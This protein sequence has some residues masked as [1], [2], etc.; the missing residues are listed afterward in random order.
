MFVSTLEVIHDFL[1]QK[2]LALVGVSRD[3]KAFS[4]TLFRDLRDRGYDM[5]PVNPEADEID[6][7]HCYKRVQDVDPAVEGAIVMTPAEKSEQ[8]VQ[9]CVAAGVERVWLHRGAGVG[10]VSEAAVRTCREFELQVV[11]GECPFMFLPHSQW[12]HRAHG[13]FRQLSGRYPA[14]ASR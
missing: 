8:V 9:D 4:R 14:A 11:E 10:A 5:V 6:G 12:V 13:L 2:R 1:A 7:A 3:S